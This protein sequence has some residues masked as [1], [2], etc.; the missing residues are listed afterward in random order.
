M[1][2]QISVCAQLLRSIRSYSSRAADHESPA[3]TAPS[4]MLRLPA[5]SLYQSD[6]DVWFVAVTGLTGLPV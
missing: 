3:M 4:L 1:L 5:A 2:C 6:C